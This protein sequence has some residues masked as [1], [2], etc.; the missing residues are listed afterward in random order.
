MILQIFTNFWR[1]STKIYNRNTKKMLEK[2]ILIVYNQFGIFIKSA[3][4][5]GEEV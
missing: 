5:K 2:T 4:P 1:N 3:L